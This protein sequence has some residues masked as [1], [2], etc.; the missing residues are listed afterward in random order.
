MSPDMRFTAAV[1][2]ICYGIIGYAAIHHFGW[3][4]GLAIVA[5]VHILEPYPMIFRTS[6][7]EVK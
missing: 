6:H 2:L 4:D 1:L 3:V 5:V 7:L